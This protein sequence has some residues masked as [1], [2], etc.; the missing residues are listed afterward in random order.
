MD[1]VLVGA[2]LDTSEET[3]APIRAVA[4]GKGRQRVGGG[5]RRRS[6]E[7]SLREREEREDFA[8]RTAGR[9]E[10]TRRGS[11]ERVRGGRDERCGIGGR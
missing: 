8:N 4:A 10:G 1:V 6:F 3:W 7:G 2:P 5:R 9:R 11:G